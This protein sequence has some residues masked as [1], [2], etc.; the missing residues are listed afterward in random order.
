M[1][2][3]LIGE[4]YKE[5]EKNPPHVLIMLPLPQELQILKIRTIKHEKTFFAC[6]WWEETKTLSK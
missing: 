5:V 6:C 2:R 1:D 3:T 4:V